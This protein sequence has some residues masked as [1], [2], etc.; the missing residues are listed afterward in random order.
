MK[1]LTKMTAL[2]VSI[3]AMSGAV[4]ANPGAQWPSFDQVDKNKDGV[5]EQSE[6][7]AIKG[8]N[9]KTVD[10]DSDGKISQVEYQTA[11]LKSDQQGGMGG[12]SAPQSGSGG[13]SAPQSSYPR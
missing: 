1:M 9:F 3:L 11:Q 13:E 6:A 5:L 4:Y 7:K 10:A 8:L 12:E 2:A